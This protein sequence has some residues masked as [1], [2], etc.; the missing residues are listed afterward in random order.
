MSGLSCG[1][2]CH[3]FCCPPCPS[4]IASKLAFVPPDSTYQIIPQENQ[5]ILQLKLKEHAEWQYSNKEL[6]NIEVCF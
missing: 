5:N 3:L 2:I 4:R 6:K 1:E